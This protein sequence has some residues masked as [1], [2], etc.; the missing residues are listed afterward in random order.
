MTVPLT[1]RAT[2]G[3]P[4]SH[5]ELD[6]NFLALA[7]GINTNSPIE[8]PDGGTLSAEN[9]GEVYTNE[10]A[11]SLVE[12]TLPSAVAG[13]FFGFIV[14]DG[15]GIRVT[16]ATGDTIRIASAVTAAGG[17]IENTTV[18]S[19]FQFTAINSTEWVATTLVT[20]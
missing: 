13:L 20:A 6:A 9:S 16:A 4:L 15:S 11:S 10:G 17:S 1:L 8:Q 5:N 12:F 3:S 18:G 7:E 2:K 19:V 14:Q